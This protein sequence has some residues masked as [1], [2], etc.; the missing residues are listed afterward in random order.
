MSQIT[1]RSEKD[2]LGDLINRR[3]EE[4]R[5]LQR[6]IQPLQ[7]K[8][9]YNQQIIDRVTAASL[10]TET[11]HFVSLLKH[12]RDENAELVERI[13]PHQQHLDRKLPHLN[14]LREAAALTEKLPTSDFSQ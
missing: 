11:N 1:L 6:I 4:V 5:H 8:V 14:H 12:L 3:N 9:A 13:T 2:P 7:D 10:Q